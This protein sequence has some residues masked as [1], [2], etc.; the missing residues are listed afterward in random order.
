[1]NFVD[2]TA[3]YIC[4]SFEFRYYPGAVH[5]RRIPSPIQVRCRVRNSIKRFTSTVPHW[6][7]HPIALLHGLPYGGPYTDQRKENQWTHFVKWSKCDVRE[8][9]NKKISPSRRKQHKDNP[10][11]HFKFSVVTFLYCFFSP[12]NHALFSR[13]TKLSA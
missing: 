6:V 5:P 1:M 2:Q 10:D 11:K 12:N 4:Q 9:T 3:G 8:E 13:L 7:S